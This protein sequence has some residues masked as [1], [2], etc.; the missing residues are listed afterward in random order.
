LD[1]NRSKAAEA[2]LWGP[3]NKPAK[4]IRSRKDLLDD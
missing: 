1:N 3:D 2:W 4:Q